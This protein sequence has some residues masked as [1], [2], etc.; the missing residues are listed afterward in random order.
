[1][2]QHDWAPRAAQEKV[3]L[4]AAPAGITPNDGSN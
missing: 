3:R 1:L 2:A 4:G